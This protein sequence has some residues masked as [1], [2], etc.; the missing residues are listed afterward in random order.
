MDCQFCGTQL[1]SEAMACPNCGTPTPAYYAPSGASAYDPTIP[2]VSASS[3]A[4]MSASPLPPT[5]Y[6]TNPY[7]NSVQRPYPVNHYE[8][9][10][11]PPPRSP[12]KR[13][14]IIAGIVLLVLLLI[15]GGVFVWLRLTA[16]ATFTANG[17]FTV[18]DSTTTS[19]TQNGQD[20]IASY[21]EHGE[22]TGDLTGSYTLQG[23]NTVHPD[24]TGTGS[25][26]IT[27]TCTVKGKSGTL[28]QSTSYTIAADGSFQGQVFDFQGTGD[29]ASLHGQG[30]FLGKGNNGTF[31]D[32][33]HIDA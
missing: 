7:A 33:L 1:P 4:V 19:V 25:G 27:C 22:F 9:P 8:A 16:A 3:S 32:Q 5:Q 15:G 2:A 10:P 20:T 29:L 14:G 17:A 26:I 21:I 31:S 30:T 12:G 24:K 6:G 23:T 28:R 11:P 18:L 13:I